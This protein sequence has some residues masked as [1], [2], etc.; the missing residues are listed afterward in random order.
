[1][2]EIGGVEAERFT[3][4]AERERTVVSRLAAN[5]DLRLGGADGVAALQLNDGVEQDGEHET[6]LGCFARPGRET[7]EVLVREKRVGNRRVRHAPPRDFRVLRL[8]VARHVGET[9]RWRT[10]RAT[11][12][13][14]AMFDHMTLPSFLWGPQDYAYNVTDHKAD[15]HGATIVPS[16]RS[17]PARRRPS[18]ADRRRVSVANTAPPEPTRAVDPLFR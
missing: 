8:R 7:I 16:G 18:D 9:D 2:R 12:R 17:S 14:S 5:P 4:V 3:D 15:R 1:M 6:L 11:R 13:C 10:L